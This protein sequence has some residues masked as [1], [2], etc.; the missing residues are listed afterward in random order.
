MMRDNDDSNVISILLLVAVIVIAGVAFQ[1]LVPSSTGFSEPKK[2]LP[3]GNE[4]EK[5]KPKL[6]CPSVSRTCKVKTE[7]RT[8]NCQEEAAIR[9]VESSLGNPLEIKEC[10]DAEAALAEDCALGCRFDYSSLMVIS[11][12]V[13]ADF[14][15]DK[16][17]SGKCLVKGRRTVT[18]KASCVPKEEPSPG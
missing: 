4:P 7:L 2:E 16:D 11:G 8:E 12:Q 6:Y 13:K 10:Q 1:N 18:I 14:S 15:P 3:A 17:E 5:T 9:E